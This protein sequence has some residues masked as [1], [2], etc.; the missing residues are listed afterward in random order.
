[1]T[2]LADGAWE[3]GDQYERSDD[4]KSVP[5]DAEAA[6]L[7]G[8]IREVECPVEGRAEGALAQPGVH[9]LELS[10]LS[11]IERQSVAGSVQDCVKF[12]EERALSVLADGLLPGAGRVVDLAFEVHDVVASLQA[13]DSADPVLEAPIPSPV[14]GLGFTLEIPLGSGKD[15]QPPPPLALCIGPD[16]PSLTGGWA[17]DSAEHDE[18]PESCGE[19]AEQPPDDAWEEQLEL[20]LERHQAASRRETAWSGDA[21]QRNSD[22]QRRLATGLIV[23]TDLRPLWLPRRRKLRAWALYVLAAQYAQHHRDNSDLR[24]FSV[25]VIADRGR[26]CGLWIWLAQPAAQATQEWF[27]AMSS[28]RKD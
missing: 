12:L 13:L 16:A 5:G 6:A 18:Q 9:L 28:T 25:L 3:S 10:C 26:R 20:E 14:P 21:G 4:I 24:R 8:D 22:A 1:M 19:A 2:R 11:E 7:V 17:L 15:G 23:E 27:T